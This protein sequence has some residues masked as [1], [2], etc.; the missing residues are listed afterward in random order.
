MLLEKDE[1]QIARITQM[2]DQ[3]CLP[4]LAGGS[5]PWQEQIKVAE[6]RREKL[7]LELLAFVKDLAKKKYFS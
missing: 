6:K 2:D 4:V 3:L 1:N 7:R 5:D